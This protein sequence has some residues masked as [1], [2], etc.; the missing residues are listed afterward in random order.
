[1]VIRAE[2][3]HLDHNDLVAIDLQDHS[4]LLSPSDRWFGIPQSVRTMLI[5][6]GNH[7]YDILSSH[8]GP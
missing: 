8:I 7:V 3:Q 5:F 2:V 6:V 1:M 4:C